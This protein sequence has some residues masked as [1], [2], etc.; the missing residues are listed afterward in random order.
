MWSGTIYGQK[1]E[2]WPIEC[3]LAI[4]FPGFTL[5]TPAGAQHGQFDIVS[6]REKG[7]KGLGRRRRPRRRGSAHQTS[8]TKRLTWKLL[9]PLYIKIKRLRV[10]EFETRKSWVRG[11]SAIG[12]WRLRRKDQQINYA[13]V[14]RPRQTQIFQFRASPLCST[15]APNHSAA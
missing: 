7:W 8:P 9:H 4:V 6:Q 1:T 2:A 12:N 13:R 10:K 11:S 14:T 5:A 3:A 15:M